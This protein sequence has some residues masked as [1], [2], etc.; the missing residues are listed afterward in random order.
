[1]LKKITSILF[2]YFLELIYGG[3]KKN[4]KIYIVVFKIKI[5]FR[6]NSRFC[7]HKKESIRFIDINEN[8]IT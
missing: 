6:N 3:L 8:L 2:G 7:I 5:N 4:T 1:M